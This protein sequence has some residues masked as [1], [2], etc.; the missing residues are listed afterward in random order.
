MSLPVAAGVRAG[1]LAVASAPVTVAPTATGA[2]VV[3]VIA[4]GAAL[5]LAGVLAALAAGLAALVVA[6]LVARVV[7]VVLVVL[8]GSV[9]GRLAGGCP[10]GGRDGCRAS[11]ARPAGR[12]SGAAGWPAR[13]CP[14]RWTA[15][16]AST[17][18]GSRERWRL[19][20]FAVRAGAASLSGLAATASA[21]SAAPLF[22]AERLSALSVVLVVFFW[23]DLSALLAGPPA[24]AALIAATRSLFLSLVVLMPIPLASCCSSG[25]NMVLREGRLAR[26]PLAGAAAAPFA[27]A[28]GA[29]S[30]MSVT[31]VSD[32]SEVACRVRRTGR[33]GTRGA[34][35]CL[36]RPAPRM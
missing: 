3:V 31:V 16:G 4:L 35:A 32:P 9:G 7:L 27:E 23:V 11:A 19:V 10:A 8:V 15:R 30:W 36:A 20:P 29:C 14:R 28:A 33:A 34:P 13:C 5:V 21:A 25:S 26:A 18:R 1:A 24:W 12:R 17:V 22:L 6:G 2:A